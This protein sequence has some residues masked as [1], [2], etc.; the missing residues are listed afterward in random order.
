MQ[1]PA[2][3][4]RMDRLRVAFAGFGSTVAAALAPAAL[5]TLYVAP[6]AGDRFGGMTLI[7]FCVAFALAFAHALLL[8][9]PVALALHH[10]CRFSLLPMLLAGTLVGIVPSAL[11]F[12]PWQSPAQWRD[13]LEIVAV[14]AV[15]GA[16]GGSAFYLSHCAISPERAERPTGTSAPE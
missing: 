5:A 4:D 11:V 2:T 1:P 14:A 15:L 6:S 10:N 13:Y 7:V 12:Y 8:G 9:L 16:I 3:S